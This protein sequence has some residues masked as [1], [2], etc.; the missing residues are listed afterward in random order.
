MERFYLTLS[1]SSDRATYGFN[2]I[3]HADDNLA[4]DE[5][6]VT[7]HLFKA[8][9]VGVRKKYVDLV[10]S[11][12]EHG[13]KVYVFSS[14]HV[15]GAQ[16][17]QYTGIAATLRFPL[18]VPSNDFNENQETK[19]NNQNNNHQNNSHQN[20]VNN[21]NQ[22]KK[23]E[24]EEEKEEDDEDYRPIPTYPFQTNISNKLSTTIST[25]SQQSTSFIEEG[26]KRNREEGKEDEEGNN[27][28]YDND[29][30]LDERD[31]NDLCDDFIGEERR[32]R[33]SS[34][35]LSS[36]ETLNFDVDMMG[37]GKTNR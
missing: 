31:R 32:R 10:E 12:R 7:D 18:I 3:K 24:N 30:N 16:L 22:K 23:I 36:I 17:D 35:D 15:S 14:M 29:Y 2:D 34:A 9:D 6:L 21:K 27:Y 25:S 26:N 8:A 13:G 19:V 5:L 28:N 37:L 11:V 20:N 4:V 33:L 1:N